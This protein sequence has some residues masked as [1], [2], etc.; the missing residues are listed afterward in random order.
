MVYKFISI[1]NISFNIEVE[2][3]RI[4]NIYLR[5]KDNTI[6]V[7]CSKYVSD[8]FINDFIN[9]KKDWIFNTYNKQNNNKKL[10]YRY[11]LNDNNI[12]IYGC[13]YKI[14]YIEAKRN[15]LVF[16]NN[17][18]ILYHKDDNYLDYLYKKLDEFLM[19]KIKN[20]VDKYINLLT[21]NGYFMYPSIKIGKFKS[22]WGEC[23]VKHNLVKFSSY[24][25]H[26]P[27]CCIDYLVVHELSHFIVPNH[28][29]EFYSLVSRYCPDYKDISK[30][31]I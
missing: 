28:S 12:Y 23:L 24:L 20:T 17:E 7:T 4:K 9:D 3:K 22:K 14:N 31:L 8:K 16:N 15:K 25:V 10:T 18:F 1:N 19:I 6:K 30:I 26:Y 29:S 11:N 27:T 21:D 13:L 2:Y 5:V